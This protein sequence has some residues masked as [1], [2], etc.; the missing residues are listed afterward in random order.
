MSHIGNFSLIVFTI[1]CICTAI[2]RTQFAP[3]VCGANSTIVVLF[4]YYLHNKT[5]RDDLVTLMSSE[6]KNDVVFLLFCC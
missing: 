6:R 4:Q 3:H 1:I 2:Y 5:W